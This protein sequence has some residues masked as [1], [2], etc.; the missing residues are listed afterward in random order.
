MIQCY[1]GVVF[2]RAVKIQLNITQQRQRNHR[3]TRCPWL[4]GIV[5]ISAMM[6]LHEQR[7]VSSGTH[8]Q[9]ASDYVNVSRLTHD[10]CRKAS[11][12]LHELP[13]KWQISV[14]GSPVLPLIQ[15][16]PSGRASGTLRDQHAASAGADKTGKQKESEREAG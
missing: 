2:V 14:L 1:S 11:R 15:T 12:S 9:I 3:F 10:P 5:R 4:G 13:V 6:S 8:P 16:S 7:R